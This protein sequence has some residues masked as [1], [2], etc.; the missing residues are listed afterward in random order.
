MV[1]PFSVTENLILND[2]YEA[3]HAQ[4][5]SVLQLPLLSTSYALVMAAIFAIIGYGWLRI[6]NSTLWSALLDSFNVPSG[7][8]SVPSGQGLNDLQKA[9]LDDPLLLSLIILIVMTSLTGLVAY[10]L[11]KLI[12]RFVGDPYSFIPPLAVAATALVGLMVVDGISG[13]LSASFNDR[14]FGAITSLTSSF[15][16]QLSDFSYI[17][18]SNRVIWGVL[19]LL[20][21]V[22]SG[23]LYSWFRDATKGSPELDNLKQR[24]RQNR[25]GQ[26]IEMQN[27]HGLTLDVEN[28]VG[29]AN[30]LIKEYDIRTPSAMTS[31]GS[32]S[33]GNQQKLVVAREF[34][35]EP[36]LLIAAQPTR[37]ID[38]GSIEFIHRRIIEQRDKG[39]AVLLVSAELDEVMSLSDR[40][41]VM[42]KGEVIKVLDAKDATREEL[43]LLMAG[44]VQK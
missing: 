15:L 35:R 39:A 12:F 24:L 17:T 28:S 5:P 37:G 9:Y 26:F 32:L 38:V 31:G 8:R 25:I 29:Y 22:I 21:L 16:G 27:A 3:P 18:N 33:G 43:G 11:T 10:L 14:F 23:V 7:F 36:R 19:C 34:I 1:K 4:S 44:I 6:W 2:Y 40:I 20:F 41:A 13:R 42:Y 30:R